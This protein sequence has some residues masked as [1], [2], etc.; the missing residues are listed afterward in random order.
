MF[1]RFFKSNKPIMVFIIPIIAILVWLPNLIDPSG[2]SIKNEFAM[3]FSKWLNHFFAN[4]LILFHILAIVVNSTNAYLINRINNQYILIADRTY[5][6]AFIY[7]LLSAFIVNSP[8]SLY[9]LI[10]I[11]LLLIIIFRVYYVYSDKN[12]LNIYFESSFL[13]GLG[14]LFFFNFWVIILFIWMSL[15]YLRQFYWREYFMVILGFIT[16]FFF[17]FAVY[18][19]KDQLN[20]YQVFYE[21]N[22]ISVPKFTLALKNSV[23]YG[24][25]SFMFLLS[26][27]S[28]NLNMNK[29]KI[30]TRKHY[31]LFLWLTFIPVVA[32][33]ILPNITKELFIFSAVPLAFIY[34]N[35]FVSIRNKWM[36]EVL[37]FLFLIGISVLYLPL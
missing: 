27:F 24:T 30:I 14:A 6:P 1:L 18:F 25:I 33:L 15:M 19:L 35:F 13:I 34:A 32:Y 26:V 37:F 23:F 11:L 5:L 21:N 29:K 9:L 4:K 16:P 3:P 10:N 31:K 36:R 8:F 2:I 28:L 12:M 17:V 22:F 20:A 7:L